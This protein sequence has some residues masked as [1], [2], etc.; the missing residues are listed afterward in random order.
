VTAVNIL[1]AMD[2]V[3]W[4]YVNNLKYISISHV[5]QE[6]LGIAAVP[7]ELK[8]IALD[9][10]IAGR[11]RYEHWATPAYSN[12][13]KGYYVQTI[14]RLIS[15][16]ETVEFKPAALERFVEYV[17]LEDKFSKRSLSEVVPEWAPWF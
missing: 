3:D 15:T 1:G 16:V 2:F 17:K 9:R 4:C 5:F 13:E 6:H 8:I 7:P 11:K 12:H 14:D 10:L